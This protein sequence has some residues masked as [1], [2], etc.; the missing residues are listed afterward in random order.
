MRALLLCDSK[1][2][3]LSCASCMWHSVLSLLCIASQRLLNPARFEELRSDVESYFAR[4]SQQV[5]IPCCRM[6]NEPRHMNVYAMHDELSIHAS[7]T[8]H[9]YSSSAILNRPLVLVHESYSLASLIFHM[10]ANAFNCITR[11]D[12]RNIEAMTKGIKYK[13]YNSQSSTLAKW[14]S[15]VYI[16]LST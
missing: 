11:H 4:N 3:I 8:L 16:I 13:C 2:T 12:I 7:M 5:C 10:I 6:E 9:I 1:P 15:R 14:L